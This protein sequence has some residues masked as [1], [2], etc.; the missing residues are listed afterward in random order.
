MKEVK[1][2]Y[3]KALTRDPSLD[4]EITVMFSLDASGAT[5]TTMCAQDGKSLTDAPLRTC[6]SSKASAS[7]FAKPKSGIEGFMVTF[8]FTP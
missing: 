3:T 7:T 8:D 1:E 5:E 4:G 6:V 2:C